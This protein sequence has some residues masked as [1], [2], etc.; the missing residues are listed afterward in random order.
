ML[1]RSDR[2]ALPEGVFTGFGGEY[3]VTCDLGRKGLLLNSY[4]RLN[5]HQLKWVEPVNESPAVSR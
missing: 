4:L 3:R 5:S 1:F 2:I